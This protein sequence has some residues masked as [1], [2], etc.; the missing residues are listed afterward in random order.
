MTIRRLMPIIILLCLSSVSHARWGFGA[1]L[2]HWESDADD[3][4]KELTAVTS[5][6]SF[7]GPEEGSVNSGSLNW[8]IEG[9]Y[10]KNFTSRYQFGVSLGIGMAPAAELNERLTDVSPLDIM[11]HFKTETVVL[12]LSFYLKRDFDRPW[13][14]LA[15]VGGDYIRSRIK[16]DASDSSGGASGHFDQDKL[17]P[18]ILAGA[19]YRLTRQISL[20]LNLKYLFSAV[21][22]DFRGDFTGEERQMAMEADPP[23]GE[24]IVL[25]GA[26]EPLT[27]D[28][29]PFKMDFGGL[30]INLTTRY[31]FGG[32]QNP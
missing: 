28:Q 17:V 32:A 15:G 8:G 1:H 29:R 23:Y 30:R 21:L 18:H 12:P 24:F 16:F 3:F 11:W 6:P 7:A 31:Y 4:Q 5:D 25:P 27:S 10:E 14:F 19:E 26:S 22:E 9:F 13:S 20:G 2:G